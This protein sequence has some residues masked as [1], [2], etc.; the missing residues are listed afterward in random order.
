MA[1]EAGYDVWLGNL[2]GNKHSRHH[3]YL[4]PDTKSRE[5]FDFDL[6]HH[7]KH[8]L[9]SIV[10]YIRIQT[11]EHFPKIAYVG[12]SMGTT[13]MFRLGAEDPEFVRDNISTVIALGPVI[14]PT[15]TTSPIVRLA[16]QYNKVLY[17]LFSNNKM[18]EFLQTTEFSSY[19]IE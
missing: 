3:I 4:D 16:S 8:D 1:A 14:V 10:G 15:F 17:N 5:F 13:I 2:R 12:H 11:R 7:S 6:T 9:K 18:Y 19:F